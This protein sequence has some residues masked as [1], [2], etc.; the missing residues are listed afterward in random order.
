MR[1]EDCHSDK[2]GQFAV[3]TDEENEVLRQTA[4]GH[5]A[6]VRQTMFDRL[7][8]EQQKSLSEIMRIVAEGLRP[9]R[10]A[11]A[12]P[13]CAERAAGAGPG[14]RT[15]GASPPLT[16]ERNERPGGVPRASVRDDR[17]RQ[18]VL[19]ALAGGGDG[20]LARTPC[21]DEG[22]GNQG[23]DDQDADGEPDRAGVTLHLTLQLD[24][25]L[26]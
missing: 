19:D 10:R 11:R 18:L 23:R 5:V 16:Y 1:R 3:L 14:Y 4:P 21:V 6:A 13:G 25:L 12:C 15:Y 22:Q 8:P 7:S 9:A 20:G 2:R 24:Q 17:H 26:L